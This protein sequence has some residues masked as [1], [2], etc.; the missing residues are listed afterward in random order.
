ME[1]D[2]LKGALGRFKK[3][4]GIKEKVVAARDPE[5]KDNYYKVQRPGILWN[6]ENDPPLRADGG[7]KRPKL[8]QRK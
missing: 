7:K 2:Y 5:D 4:A 3:L 6:G 8:K 1:E